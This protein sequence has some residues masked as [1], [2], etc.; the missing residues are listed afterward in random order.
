MT[1]DPIVAEVPEEDDV[2][3]NNTT[4]W[5][6]TRTWIAQQVVI[7]G[8]IAANAVTTGWSNLET[9]GVILAV[10]AAIVSYLVPDKPRV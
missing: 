2:P 4:T 8:G 9:K 7:F 10:V 5:T 6:P 3:Q 1:N